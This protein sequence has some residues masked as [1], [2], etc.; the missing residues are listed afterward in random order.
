MDKTKLTTTVKI[1]ELIRI[2]KENRARHQELYEEATIN[3]RKSLVRGFS[4]RLEQARKHES[5]PGHNKE[6]DCC[7]RVLRPEN[8]LRE[9]DTLIQML[10]M[11]EDKLITLDENDFAKYVRDEW[12]W[13]GSFINSVN[14]HGVKLDD[15]ESEYLR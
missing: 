6:P 11:T 9:Y 13:K 14:P 5:D 8:H 15:L 4:E 10:S 7:I 12:T 2:L 3:Y 1:S